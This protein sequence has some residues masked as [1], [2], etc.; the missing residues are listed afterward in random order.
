MQKIL[1]LKFSIQH[2]TGIQIKVNEQVIFDK[3]LGKTSVRLKTS[4]KA[5]TNS[6]LM[7]VW[8]SKNRSMI[9]TEVVLIVIMQHHILL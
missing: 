8:S 2:L 1:K 3:V 7:R 5:T 9:L 4:W 6:A